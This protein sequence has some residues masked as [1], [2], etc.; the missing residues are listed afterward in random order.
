MATDCSCET[1]IVSL[2]TYDCSPSRTSGAVKCTFH[3]V[4]AFPSL[5]HHSVTKVLLIS[6]ATVPIQPATVTVSKRNMSGVSQSQ[7]KVNKLPPPYALYTKGS[8]QPRG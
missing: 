1:I 7:L 6:Y 8:F 4:K 3:T 2:L 5:S